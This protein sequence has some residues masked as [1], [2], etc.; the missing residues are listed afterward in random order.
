METGQ[1]TMTGPAG[2][3]LA[4]QRIKDAYLGE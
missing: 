4:D 3:L 2:Q 1:I